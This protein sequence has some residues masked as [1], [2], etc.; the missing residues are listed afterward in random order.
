MDAK[1]CAKLVML[2]LVA[3]I[4]LQASATEVN[5]FK[6]TV[7]KG[8]CGFKCA[9][10]FHRKACFRKCYNHCVGGASEVEKF[11]SQCNLDCTVSKCLRLHLDAKKVKG[12]VNSCL[13]NCKNS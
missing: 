1:S 12:C 2:M 9:L 3:T 6:S 4:A 10:N 7:C 8:T 5:S 13:E 11:E